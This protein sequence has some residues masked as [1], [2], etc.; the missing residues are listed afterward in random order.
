LLK[1]QIPKRRS[2]NILLQIARFPE[3]AASH[4]F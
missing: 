1:H 2:V 3:G 4:P